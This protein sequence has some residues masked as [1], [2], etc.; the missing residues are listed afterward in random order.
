MV[1]F[2]YSNTKNTN[3][4]Y[5][6]FELNYNYYPRIFFEDD[7]NLYLKFYSANKLVNELKNLI[8]TYQQNLIHTQKLEKQTY[9]KSVKLYNYML[10]NKI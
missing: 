10:S 2:V 7:V 4:G 9:N 6:Q 5:I 1:K 8:L 3:I